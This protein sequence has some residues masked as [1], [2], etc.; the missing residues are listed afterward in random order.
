MAG[1]R[2]LSARRA[3][4]SLHQGMVVDL[5]RA[6][7]SRSKEQ[8]VGRDRPIGEAQDAA[9]EISDQDVADVVAIIRATSSSINE[10]KSIIAHRESIIDKQ[11]KLIDQ[12][13]HAETMANE[14][15]TAKEK[16]CVYEKGRADRAEALLITF[17]RQVRLLEEQSVASQT[18]LSKLARAVRDSLGANVQ[19][20]PKR[21]IAV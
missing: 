1:E 7:S 14:D 9:N 13:R 16:E 10:F 12:M 2:I 6:S 18:N 4:D 5:H 21:A 8:P 17:E 3:A 19:S 11:N 20:L 15:Y